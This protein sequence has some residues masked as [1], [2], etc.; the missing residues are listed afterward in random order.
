MA[1]TTVIGFPLDQPII[2]SPG[3]MVREADAPGNAKWLALPPEAPQRAAKGDLGET[4]IANLESKPLSHE[5]L[6]F[7]NLRKG[8]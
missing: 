6:P 8:K 4:T 2:T 7:A 3:V 5:G 1:R